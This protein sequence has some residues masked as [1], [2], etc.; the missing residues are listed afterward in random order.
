MN[1]FTATGKRAPHDLRPHPLND[2]IYGDGADPD[3]I[4]SIRN[5]GILNPL[6]ITLDNLIISGHR[7]WE[8]SVAVGLDMLPVVVFGSTDTLDIEEAL[9]ESNRQRTKNN[10]QIGREYKHLKRI[11]NER[12]SKQGRRTDLTSVKDFTEVNEPA[13]RAAEKLG[14]SKP[15]AHK[16][17]R[18][19]DA[20]DKL[21][22]EGDNHSAEHLRRK[23][24]HSVNGAYIEAKDAGVIESPKPKPK[25]T[26]KFVTVPQWQTAEAQDKAEW[27]FAQHGSSHAFNQTNENVEWALWTWNPVTG[28]LHN[29]PY[30][31]ARDIANRFYAHL[32]EGERFAP[33]F[34][35][36]RLSAPSN[37]K[38]PDLNQIDDPVRRMGLQ[39]VFVCSM[40][41]LFGKWVPT[42]WINAVL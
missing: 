9:I 7:R 26:Y 10:E 32:P 6:L 31:Y 37:T 16:A 23:L 3:L 39:N 11:Y 2:E 19:I 42:E 41:D 8:A 24:E 15:T 22:T 40:A 33:V 30:C 36:E 27:L 1:N 25:P 28:C 13:V 29:C 21:K 5:K 14:V 20:I 18:V 38:Q 17:E 34:Y 12:D 35:P 4:E